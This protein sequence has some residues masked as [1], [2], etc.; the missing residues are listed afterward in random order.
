MPISMLLLIYAM[1]L[2]LMYVLHAQLSNFA[3]SIL[4]SFQAFCA[5]QVENSIC[6]LVNYI[7]L[8]ILSF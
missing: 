4:K 5:L 8:Q 7:T 1:I 2:C 3:N 6:F